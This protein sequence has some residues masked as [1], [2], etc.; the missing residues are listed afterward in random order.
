MFSKFKLRFRFFH[1]STLNA[2]STVYDKFFQNTYILLY[3]VYSRGYYDS[4]MLA[5]YL[6]RTMKVVYH[7]NALTVHSSKTTKKYH[8]DIYSMASYSTVQCSS[9]SPNLIGR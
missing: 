2:C 6:P 5:D 7:S 1:S 9:L 4:T 3:F 8:V